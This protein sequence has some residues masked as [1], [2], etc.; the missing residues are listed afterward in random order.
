MKPCVLNS[1]EGHGRKKQK[2]RDPDDNTGRACALDRMKVIDDDTQEPCSSF[3]FDDPRASNESPVNEID[4][5]DLEGHG[6]KEQ[7]ERDPDDNTGRACAL[8]RMKLIDDDTHK[9]CSLFNCDAPR[10]SNES[11]VNEIDLENCTSSDV[12]NYVNGFKKKKVRTELIQCMDP[13]NGLLDYL[14]EYDIINDSVIN[15]LYL[16]PAYRDV[17]RILLRNH[18]APKIESCCNDFLKALRENEQEHIVKFIISSVIDIGWKDR[19]LT[20]KERNFIDRNTFCLMKLINPYSRDF[21]DLLSQAECITSEHKDKIENLYRKHK[22]V[23]ELLKILQRRTYNDFNNFKKCLSQT[24]QNKLIDLLDEGRVAEVKVKL[25]KQMES[26]DKKVIE[27]KLI[28]ILTGY[29]DE[30]DSSPITP[31]QNTIINEVLQELK[32]AGIYFIGICHSHSMAL[33]FKYYTDDSLQSL[34]SYCETGSLKA[35]LER[36]CKFLLDFPEESPCLL[37]QVN[38]IQYTRSDDGETHNIALRNF[39]CNYIHY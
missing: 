30:S 17:N 20:K 33:Y 22:N 35:L 3:N 39:K 10:A 38:L 37:K 11:P 34:I 8:D 28:E 16:E 21:I 27:I 19:L 13:E 32:D 4:L 14:S 2:E 29:V 7:K 31:E 26:K 25:L 24:M 15:D 6:R 36:L 1:F 23:H 12:E 18:I 5:S 9:P